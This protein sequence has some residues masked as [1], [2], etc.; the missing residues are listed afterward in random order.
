MEC[1][2]VVCLGAGFVGGPTMA[3]FAYKC[4][5]ISFT[6]LDTDTQK[7]AMWNSDS[8]PF[9]EPGLLDVVKIARDRNLVFSSNI[10]EELITASM[11]FIA[12]PTPT[13]KYGLGSGVA[14]D[15]SYFEQAARGIAEIFRDSKSQIIIVEKSTVPVRAAEMIKDIISCNCPELKFSVLSNP[16]FLAEG[17]AINDLLYPN[18]VL[19]G[20]DNEL[21][22]STL[23]SLYANWVP[24]EKII[25]T[26][27]SSSEISKLCANAMLAQRISSVNSLS[28]LCEKIGADISQVSK[29]LGKDERI[30]EKFLQASIGFG[31]S[32]FTK[33]ILCLVYICEKEGLIEVANY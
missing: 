31:G 27:L 15:L 24:P 11:V 2:K 28:A 1:K 19:I 8:L 20:G 22:I 32:C 17:T 25:S 3:I 33:D 10:R 16:E 5:E 12:V 29:V 21:A 14:C 6:V 26:S 4:P 13:K 23:A 7:V 9:Y 30:G 18:R